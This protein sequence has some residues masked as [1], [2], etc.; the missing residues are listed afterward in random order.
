MSTLPK[1]IFIG[2]AFWSHQAI[3]QDGFQIKKFGFK[4]GLSNNEVTTIL[5]DKRGFMWIGTRDGLNRFDGDEFRTYRENSQPGYR[6]SSSSVEDL[7]EDSKGNIWIGTKTGGVD[8]Y[9]PWN[10]QIRQFSY[11]NRQTEIFKDTRIVQVVEDHNHEVWLIARDKGIYKILNDSTFEEH[12]VG[13]TIRKVFIDKNNLFWLATES[14]LILY[15][16]KNRTG[17][18]IYSASGITSIEFDPGRGKIWIGSWGTGL[19][20]L[21]LSQGYFSTPTLEK[22]R[23]NGSN[24]PL[25]VYSLML[26]ENGDLWAGTWGDGLFIL[27]HEKDQIHHFTKNYKNPNTLSS[28]IVLTIYEDRSG[29]VWAGTDRGGVHLFKPNETG[30]HRLEYNFFEENSFSHEYI[31]CVITDNHHN[32]VAGTYGG[33]I[34]KISLRNGI[35]T[36]YNQSLGGPYHGDNDIQSLLIDSHGSLWAGDLNVGLFQFYDFD[37]NISP[38]FTNLTAETRPKING[39][40]VTSLLEDSPE[41]I[42]VGTQRNG[43]N[44]VDLDHQGRITRVLHDNFGALDLNKRITCILNSDGDYLWVGTYKGLLK[45]PKQRMVDKSLSIKKITGELISSAYRDKKGNIWIGTPNGLQYIDLQSDQP[46][47]TRYD[48]NHGLSHNYVTGITASPDEKF[49]WI[50]TNYGLNLFDTLS[51]RFKTFYKEDGLAGNTFSPNG[52]YRAEN[53]EIF[54]GASGGI[55]YFHSDSIKLKDAPPALVITSL[56]I[57]DDQDVKIGESYWGDVLL[58]KPLY[59]TKKIILNHHI[60]K[61]TFSFSTLDYFS[62]SKAINYYKLEDYNDKWIPLSN[63]NYFSF[64]NLGRGEYNLLIRTPARHNSKPFN[65]TSLAI[66]IL[67]PPWAST[68]AII[69]YIILGLIIGYGIFRMLAAQGNLRNKLK[70]EKI[71]REKEHELHQLKLQFFTNISHELRTP[72]TLIAGP[73]EELSRLNDKDRSLQDK[74]QLMHRN[75]RRLL[76]L[77]D[78][79]I[80]FRKVEVEKMTLNLSKNDLVAFCREIYQLFKLGSGDDKYHFYFNSQLESLDAYF[81]LP[82]L[83]TIIYN[84]ISNAVKF[85][86]KEGGDIGIDIKKDPLSPGYVTI[87]VSDYGIGISQDHIEK[88]FKRF[89]QLGSTTMNTGAGIGLSLVKRLVEMHNGTIRVKSKPGEGTKISLVFPFLKEKW[90][91]ELKASD[92]LVLEENTEWVPKYRE[93]EIQDLMG[94]E[95]FPESQLQHEGKASL[96]I[97]DDNEDLRTYLDKIFAPTYEVYHACNGIEALSL[98]D[99]QPVD[100]II[101][102]IM[103][104]EMDGVELCQKIKITSSYSHVPIV[105]LS[106][107]VEVEDQLSGLKIG[108]DDYVEKPFNPEVLKAKVRNLLDKKNEMRRYYR[109]EFLMEAERGEIENLDEKFILDVK[110]IVENNIEDSNRIKLLIQEEM[111]MSKATFYRKLKSLTGYSLSEFIRSIR[112]KKAAILLESSSQNISQIAYSVGFNDLKYFRTCFEGE[113]RQT[114]TE[115][116]NSHKAGTLQGK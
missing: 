91:Q 63:Q 58:S 114:P 56:K 30:F 74:I 80:T 11:T 10:E 85:S 43:L 113:F 53:G 99:K 20:S 96:L 14:G 2:I 28:D 12:P 93:Q 9:D 23:L 94:G 16:I 86:K 44:R 107:K 65:Q 68:G 72:L 64:S 61:I 103:M 26:K 115:Y 41:S 19:L 1:L 6:L 25:H 111:A 71:T 13:V 73:I 48:I 110:E 24:K 108:A 105:I 60:N 104:D 46:A 38:N 89:Y 21:D 35:I 37:G 5:Q 100:M 49:I 81:D 102:D 82:M 32:L 34:N 40:K 84:L 87:S 29:M 4:D 52:V 112:V 39:Y 95:V 8:K 42:W 18:T 97:V 3:G 66:T 83:E 75:V 59:E 98:L 7:F 70:I 45:Y 55:T 31:S 116:R 50:S 78:Q 33:G 36:K 106:A 57:N 90:Y 62:S 79:L 22:H 67:P 76:R 47:I 101:T 15:D 69:G 77:S 54:F 51:Q 17:K 109:Q 27:N 92:Y 88:I